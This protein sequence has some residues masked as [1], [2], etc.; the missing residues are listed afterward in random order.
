MQSNV[1]GHVRVAE[2][3]EC[4]VMECATPGLRSGMNAE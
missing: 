4:K 2:R 1:M 3:N